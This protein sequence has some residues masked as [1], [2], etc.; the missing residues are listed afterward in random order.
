[1]ERI[2]VVDDDR[3]LLSTIGR[4]LKGH[5]YEA[6]LAAN[7]LE[8]LR[9]FRTIKPDLVITDIKMPVKEGLDMILLLRTWAPEQKIIVI[10]GGGGRGD[11]G[12]PFL[13]AP[14]LGVWKVVAKPFRAEALL[15]VVADCLA[16]APAEDGSAGDE[17]PAGAD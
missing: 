16:A 9:V 3:A 13:A 1:M 17:A 11:K 4:I 6:H 7:G 10:T 5:G 15:A 12:D 14:E 2:L 8:G